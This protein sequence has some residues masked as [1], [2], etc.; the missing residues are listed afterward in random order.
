MLNLLKNR[1]SVL[2][3]VSGS[4]AGLVAIFEQTSLTEDVDARRRRRRRHA[5]A[6]RHC[7]DAEQ[8]TRCDEHRDCCTN[9]CDKD[10]GICSV[11]AV[12]DACTSHRQCESGR[13]L[14]KICVVALTPDP[15]PSEGPEDQARRPTRTPT[16][17]GTSTPT[18]T[19]TTRATNTPTRTPTTR[20]TNT[21]TRTPTQVPTATNTATATATNTQVPTATNTPTRTPTQVPTATNTATATATNTQV[22]TATN[23][24]TAAATNTPTATAT[25]PPTWSNLTTFTAAGSSQTYT[26]FKPEGIKILPGN[27]TALVVDIDSYIVTMWGRSGLNTQDWAL[28]STFGS[29]GVEP[30][31]FSQ[32][33]G[34]DVSENGLVAAVVDFAS[35]LVSLWTRP[36]STST[37]WTYESSFGTYGDGAADFQFPWNVLLADQGC[38]AFIADGIMSRISVWSRPAT[39]STTWTH[40]YNFGW[41]I[42]SVPDD[43][44]TTPSDFVLSANGQTMYIVDHGK[45]RVAIWTRATSTATYW[46]QVNYFGIAQL[47]GKP[48]GI[49]MSPDELTIWVTNDAGV[50][51]TGGRISVWTRPDISDSNWEFAGTIGSSGSG[52]GNFSNPHGIAASSD[53]TMLM[54]S[55]TGNLRVSVWGLS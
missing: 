55:D 36:D 46:A 15:E 8:A 3:I 30:G 51:Y 19:P 20:A 32:P 31:Q 41:D 27:L 26:S 34:L 1:R 25:T 53:G 49:A 13:C 21:P 48:I 45:S 33:I 18:R 54:V 4:V 37:T 11:K 35:G 39:S 47:H 17:A 14:R 43:R 38:T 22:P 42:N 29:P 9:Y 6:E 16:R 12:G 5:H 24:A 52:N 2:A 40:Q 44:L 7:A 10:R 28:I 23:T 50:E